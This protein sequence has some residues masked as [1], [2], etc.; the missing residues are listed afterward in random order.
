MRYND[1]PEAFDLDPDHADEILS[2]MADEMERD[3]DD[4]HHERMDHAVD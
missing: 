4:Y 2:R 3:I 1:N